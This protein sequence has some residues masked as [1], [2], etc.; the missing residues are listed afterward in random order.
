MDKPLQATQKSPAN[1]VRTRRPAEQR[2]AEIVEKAIELAAKFGPD[3]LTT[4]VLARE[5]GI[6]QAAIFRHFSN[7]GAIWEAV[8]RHLAEKIRKNWELIPQDNA[9]PYAALRALVLNHLTMVKQTPAL[10]AIL[11]STELHAGNEK[12]RSFFV[13]M[14]KNFHARLTAAVAEQMNSENCSSNLEPADAASLVLSLIQGMAI[15]WSLNSRNFD[16]VSEGERLLDLQILC[17]N[18]LNR[19]KNA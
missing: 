18:S 17:F 3:R 1:P 13:E 4:E 6:S 9:Q 11:F 7:K 16:L 19:E 2:K 14:V 12:L 15:R 8:A 5:I 10:P